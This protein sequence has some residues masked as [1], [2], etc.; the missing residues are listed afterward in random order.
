[1]EQNVVQWIQIIALGGLLGAL[2]QGA[3]VVV[4]LKKLSDA[5]AATGGAA[6]QIEPS[7]MVTSL[8]IGFIA[9]ALAAMMMGIDVDAK[10]S[11]Q[12]VLGLAGAGYAGTDFIEGFLSRTPLSPPTQQTTTTTTTTTAA[13]GSGLQPV[14][15]TTADD[16]LG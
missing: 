6:E 15:A 2:G 13:T 7:R 1:M 4:G 10:V 8:L 5:T 14:I 3:R 16:Y 9:G 11:L 12:Q